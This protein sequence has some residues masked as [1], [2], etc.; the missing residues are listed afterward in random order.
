MK[1][2]VKT[3]MGETIVLDCE[4][5]DTIKDIKEK[6]SQ[7][8]L[9]ILDHYEYKRTNPN[10]SPKD[11]IENPTAIYTDLTPDKQRII[12]AG[13]QLED[14]KTLADYYIE[15]EST[16][17]LVDWRRGGGGDIPLSFVDVEKGIV[18]N[19]KFSD[20]APNWR[21]VKKGLNLFGLCKNKKCEALNKEVIHVV[22]INHKKYNLQENILNIKCPICDGIVIPETC[23][24][25]KCEY[26]FDGDK[27]EEGK[28]KHVDTKSKETI[29]DNFEYFTPNENGSCLWTN[30]NIYVIE[31][32]EMKYLYN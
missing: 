22:G 29:G 20:S 7:K 16:L 17:H 6:I 24:F 1:I 12:Y 28:L 5:S 8:K 3:L 19:L 18:E 2:F 13:K 15:K 32:Q 4:S 10:Q 23:G 11:V 31:K 27:I 30:L 25:L 9:K 14:N 26:Q 21:Y